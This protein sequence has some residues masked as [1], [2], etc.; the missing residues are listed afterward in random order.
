MP[1]ALE[2]IQEAAAATDAISAEVDRAYEALSSIRGRAINGHGVYSDPSLCRQAL[3]AARIAIS[4]AWEA[5]SVTWP[6]DA[7]Y[8]AADMVAGDE[9][10]P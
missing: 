2:T 1:N 7:D 9:P 4:T 3:A 10:D 5:S 6:T 8:D